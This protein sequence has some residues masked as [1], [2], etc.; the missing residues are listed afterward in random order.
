MKAW[1]FIQHNENSK[2]P[3]LRKKKGGGGINLQVQLSLQNSINK[4]K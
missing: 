4:I 2:V 1:Q 3:D